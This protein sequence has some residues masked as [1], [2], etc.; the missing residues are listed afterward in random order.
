[1]YSS[2]SSFSSPVEGRRSSSV[3]PII[4]QVS[5]AEPI[6]IIAKLV[7]DSRD[8]VESPLPSDLEPEETADARDSSD[9]VS[10]PLQSLM[11]RHN[12]LSNL[13]VRPHSARSPKQSE[14]SEPDSAS[15]DVEN[16]YRKIGIHVSRMSAPQRLELFKRSP[17]E[18]LKIRRIVKK[19]QR[20]RMHAWACKKNVGGFGTRSRYLQLRG[21]ILSYQ[22]APDDPSPKELNLAE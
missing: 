18:I 12:E 21:F 10:G 16:P 11:I 2:W 5:S 13:Q 3:E 6:T 9:T 15:G 17:E 22:Q 4:R 14:P 20:T 8:M 7:S 1:M 19:I